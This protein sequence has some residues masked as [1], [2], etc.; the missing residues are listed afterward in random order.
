MGDLEKLLLRA[1]L[2]RPQIIN[3]K[4]YCIWRE[5]P[6]ENTAEQKEE[7]MRSTMRLLGTDK[8]QKKRS[9]SNLLEQ[10]LHNPNAR[11]HMNGRLSTIRPRENSILHTKTS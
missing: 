9:T 11:P 3:E 6:N 2:D 10:E 4:F 1:Q 7:R 5:T 8:N